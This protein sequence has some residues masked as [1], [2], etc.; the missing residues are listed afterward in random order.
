MD[1]Q[2]V[3]RHRPN[4]NVIVIGLA[5]PPQEVDRARVTQ[6]PLKG[7]Q[8][9][10]LGLKNLRLG[11]RSVGTVEEVRRTRGHDFF[12]LRSDEHA[13]DAH[14]LKFGE[15]NDTMGK[16]SVD[17]IDTKEKGFGE[18][19][20]TR[21]NLDQP[22]SQDA[23]HFPRK[24]FLRFHIGGVRHRCL[25]CTSVRNYNKGRM[26]NTENNDEPRPL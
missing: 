1:F 25:L 20:E 2:K 3:L 4:L 13:G 15:G 10:S 26:G 17:D 22:V 5:D 23:A 21:V 16:K 18:K 11:V 7:L 6:V 14:K 24:V 9:V 19:T 8:D 12:D